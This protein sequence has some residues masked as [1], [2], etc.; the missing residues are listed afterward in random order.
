MIPVMK[1]NTTTSFTLDIKR[2]ENIKGR[3]ENHA[4]ILLP[5][6]GKEKNKKIP[7]TTA[8]KY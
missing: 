1:L 2:T 7:L 5:N 6:F 8:S 3:K 4:K